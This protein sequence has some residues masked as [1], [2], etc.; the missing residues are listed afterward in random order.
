MIN[1]IET[2]LKEEI[3]SLIFLMILLDSLPLTKTTGSLNSLKTL[4]RFGQI[5]GSTSKSIE[6]L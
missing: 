6:G 3:Q 1:F 4:M 5:S 2:T